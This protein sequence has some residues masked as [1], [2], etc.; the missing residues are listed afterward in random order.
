MGV[1]R[2]LDYNPNTLKEMK[3]NYYIPMTTIRVYYFK[4]LFPVDADKK[5]PDS[6]DISYQPIWTRV[7]FVGYDAYSLFFICFALIG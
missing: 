1:L 7:M 3:R 2:Y 6:F 5:Y 4:V